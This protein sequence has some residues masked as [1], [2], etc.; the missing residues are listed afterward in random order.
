VVLDPGCEPAR[1]DDMNDTLIRTL[2]RGRLQIL[3]LVA[4]LPDDQLAVQP[5]VGMNH[6]AWVLGHLAILDVI[7]TDALEGHPAQLAP[8]I[9]ATYGPDS[10]P[11]ADRARYLPKARLVRNFDDGRLELLNRLGQTEPAVLERTNPN[12]ALRGAFPTIGHLLQ[13]TL[14]HDGYH[15]G[16]L[17][18]WRRAQGLTSPGVSFF[19]P[20]AH[21]QAKIR[22]V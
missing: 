7:T 13:Y 12:G 14:W 20:D 10:T 2:D 1:Q 8:A 6:P 9:R 11:T 18:A 4:D 3:L 19:T 17:S 21:I 5:A 22:G 15:G 16:Q